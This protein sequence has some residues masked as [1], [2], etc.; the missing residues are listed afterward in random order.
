LG[1]TEPS[2]VNVANDRSWRLTQIPPADLDIPVLGQ[3]APAQL[4]PGDT[5]EPGPLGIVRLDAPLGMGRP[6]N[7]RWNT[8]RGTRT[9]PRYSP[10]STPNAT[11]CLSAFQRA[12][13]GKVKNIGAPLAL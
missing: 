1:R 7:S 2:D 13:S 5:L 3:L 8:R 4:P 9:T 6:A 12:S 11:A 10:I